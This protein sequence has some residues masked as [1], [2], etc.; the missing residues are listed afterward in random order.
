MTLDEGVP[1]CGNTIFSK[2]NVN[3]ERDL[4]LTSGRISCQEFIDSRFDAQTVDSLVINSYFGQT[5]SIVWLD[6]VLFAHPGAIELVRQKLRPV[7]IRA[8]GDPLQLL[9]YPQ[10]RF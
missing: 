7:R 1:G 5:L 3:L 2:E 8:S 9:Y 6:E 4:I 10:T